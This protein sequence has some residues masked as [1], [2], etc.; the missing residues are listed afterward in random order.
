MPAD[1]GELDLSMREQASFHP[2]ERGKR[3]QRALASAFHPVCRRD[4]NDMA[5]TTRGPHPEPAAG[6]WTFTRYM[7]A[8]GMGLIGTTLLSIAASLPGAPFAFKV[9]GAWFFGTPSLSQ[10]GGIA[11]AGAFALF[12]ELVCGFTGI[13]LLC[14]AWWMIYREVA[15]K[16]G[17]NPRDLAG[18]LVV[19]MVPILIAPP[20]FSDD[21]Y[22]YAAQGEMVSHHISPYL[23][24]PGVLG[25]TPFAS[26]AQ[27]I[28][29][30]TPSPYGPFFSG[31]E[32]GIVQLTGHRALL[33]VVLLRL[34][35][36]VG[37][38]LIAAFLPSLARSYGGD[39]AT[40]FSLGVLNPL[41]LLFLIGSGH[42]DAL[43]IG[44]LV[45]GLSVARRGHFTWGIVLCALAGAI[46]LPGLVG[47]FA[48]AWTSPGAAF[49]GWRRCLSLAKAT[50]IAMA[51]F[52]SLSAI[53]GV[54][55]GWVHTI[56][57][58][59][60]VTSWI[61]PFDLAAKLVPTL[62]RVSHVPV[63]R[64]A[65]LDAAHIVGPALAV[66]VSLFALRRL[67]AIGLPRAL[68][69]SLL[70]VVLLGPIVQPA[71]LMW[72]ISILAIT[73]GL[74][75]AAAIALLSVAVSLFAVV[76]LGQLAGEVASLGLLY[77]L[78]CILMLAASIVMPIRTVPRRD[79][80]DPVSRNPIRWSLA[81]AW[82]L[83]GA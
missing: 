63:S 81:R 45:A 26:L 29:I 3:E 73:A 27:G 55:W 11:Q 46:K 16:P 24:G 41:V 25:A 79:H 42:N 83:Q 12:A 18:I 51:T 62:G 72:G 56:G 35:A 70:A 23:Y 14:R 17:R 15:R 37:V 58:A 77:Q 82:N 53:F 8:A 66:A 2:L 59:D 76:G 10:G 20:M 80:S 5:S 40:A 74:R 7:G 38:G 32:G 44:L 47:V 31:L 49:S 13:I 48:I 6:S 60:T 64:I 78:L 54:G 28:W 9:P 36:V 21:I 52:E 68:G 1:R 75:T 30:S 71:Y 69:V 50:V 22:S 4:G 34:L 65:F 61:T 19:W 39:P 57:A 67:P 33:A 43:M